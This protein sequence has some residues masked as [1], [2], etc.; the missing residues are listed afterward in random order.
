MLFF[1]ISPERFKRRRSRR[2][3]PGEKMKIK[4]RVKGRPNLRQIRPTF[5]LNGNEPPGAKR[6]KYV[7]IRPSQLYDSAGAIGK[8]RQQDYIPPVESF[9]DLRCFPPLLWAAEARIPLCDSG[10]SPISRRQVSLDESVSA[11]SRT[12]AA[13]CVLCFFVAMRQ[14]LRKGEST[15]NIRANSI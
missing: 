4:K 2:S 8:A 3:K 9:G 6:E 15:G 12:A 7:R 14:P 10:E 1:K 11:G 5:K 13:W